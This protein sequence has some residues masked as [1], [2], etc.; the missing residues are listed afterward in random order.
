MYSGGSHGTARLTDIARNCVW[1]MLRS[2]LVAPPAPLEVATAAAA[3]R[4]EAA[5]EMAVA[6]EAIVEARSS[7]SEPGTETCKQQTRMAIHE[8]G[9]EKSLCLLLFEAIC[10]LD[11]RAIEWLCL[12]GPSCLN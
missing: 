5:A 11:A 10:R 12:C 9:L 8:P 2:R 1:P 7:M 4:A 6:A 3:L